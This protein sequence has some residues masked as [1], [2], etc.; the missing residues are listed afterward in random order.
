MIV[1]R[2]GFVYLSWTSGH[3]LQWTP[4]LTLARKFEDLEAFHN[5]TQVWEREALKLK[6]IEVVTLL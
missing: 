2:D 3:S 6:D 5:N 4:D 1:L